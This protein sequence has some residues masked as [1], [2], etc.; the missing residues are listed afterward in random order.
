M[1]GVVIYALLPTC[2]ILLIVKHKFFGIDSSWARFEM[3]LNF[4]MEGVV[5]DALLPTCVILLIAKHSFFGI[6]LR[7]G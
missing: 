4:R 5:I 3:Y 7:L 1:E 6:D 2:V